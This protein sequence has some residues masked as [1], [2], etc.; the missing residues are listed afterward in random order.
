[1]YFLLHFTSDVLLYDTLMCCCLML[2]SPLFG[3]PHGIAVTRCSIYTLCFTSRELNEARRPH[4]GSRPCAFKE[5]KTRNSGQIF[6]SIQN[7]KKTHTHIF[8]AFSTPVV[9]S[10]PFFRVFL[11]EVP[12]ATSEPRALQLDLPRVNERNQNVLPRAIHRIFQLAQ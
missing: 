9:V 1:M 3:Q 8:L 7:R 12:S 10:Y 11:G 2:D 6:N 4:T 5:K